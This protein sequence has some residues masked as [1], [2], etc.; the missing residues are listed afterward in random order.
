MPKASPNDL[1]EP[2]GKY[3]YER[4]DL[5]CSY[6]GADEHECGNQ[7]ECDVCGEFHWNSP[8]KRATPN[9]G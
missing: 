2:R 3:F 7:G 8:H 9:T 6:C 4:P 1:Q 5:Y